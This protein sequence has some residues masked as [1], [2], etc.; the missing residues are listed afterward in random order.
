MKKTKSSKYNFL[1]MLE[2][3]DMLIFNA[4]SNG[5]AIVNK[6]NAKIVKQLLNNPNKPN[7][8][9]EVKEL[10]SSLKRGKFILPHN[11]NEFA[12]LKYRFWKSRFNF[13]TLS[14]T[15]APTLNCNFECIYCYETWHNTPKNRTMTKKSQEMLIKFITL[16]IKRGVKVIKLNWYGGEPLL[17]FNTIKNL[18]QKIIKL[19][20]ENNVKYNAGIITNGFLL[21]D[22][23]NDLLHLGIQS[24]Q[25]TLDGPPEIHNHYRPLKG[26]GPTFS[27]I[28]ENIK[29]LAKL[30]KC[31]IGIRVN[32]SKDNLSQ[33]NELIN[34]LEKE[35]LKNKINIYP[36][37]IHIEEGKPKLNCLSDLSFSEIEVD[38]MNTLINKGWKISIPQMIKSIFC[39]AYAANSFTIDPYLNLYKCW[40]LIGLD[41][42]KVGFINEEGKP[43]FN[44]NNLIWLSLDP[45]EIEECRDCKFL[46]LCMGGC[47]A[48]SIKELIDNGNSVRG[49]CTFLKNN[50]DKKLNIYYKYLAESNT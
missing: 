14:L 30:E 11:I 6:D 28:L 18:S 38:F 21:R 37:Q 16:Y 32:I 22:K 35:G 27:V 45:F 31:N 24:F 3:G 48:N 39:S 15:I 47:L 26:G 43:V 44:E 13:H 5:F 9:V 46:P 8:S 29:S 12:Q 20:R 25:I 4:T 7:L 40:D 33:V 49:K 10:L 17:T 19:C 34:I 23:F 42:Y 1:A 2:T 50:L 41:D 36:G